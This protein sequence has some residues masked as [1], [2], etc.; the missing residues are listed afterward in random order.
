MSRRWTCAPVALAALL[1]ACTASPPPPPPTL[2]AGTPAPNATLAAVA[3]TPAAPAATARALPTPTLPPVVTQAAEK[4]PP[5]PGSTDEPLPTARDL[6]NGTVAAL[7]RVKTARLLATLANGHRTDLL[8][9]APDRAA[10][11]E[12]DATNREV[13]RYVIIGDTGYQ[14]LAAM[15]GNWTRTQH[16]DFRKQAQVFRALQI[17]LATGRP[18]PLDSGAEVE[19]V[20]WQGKPALRAA[21]EYSASPELEELGLMRTAQG[22]SVTVIVD[23]ET[24]LPFH[25]REE[26][27]GYVTEVDFVEFDQPRTIEPPIP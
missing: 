17:A 16:P 1:L 9:V 24:W 8:Y 23:P 4:A 21:F 27:Q 14:N 15:G 3:A 22:N 10:L 2:P 12:Q 13:A 6:A 25:S 5:P 26:T 7:L 19:V 20:E 18:R 11:V